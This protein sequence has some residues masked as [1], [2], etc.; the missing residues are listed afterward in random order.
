M[1]CCCAPKAPEND[2]REDDDAT[3][4]HFASSTSAHGFARVVGSRY[5]IFKIFWALLILAGFSIASIN[6]R[7]RFLSF[8][9]HDTTTK[10]SMIF[11]KKLQFPAVTICNANK[12]NQKLLTENDEKFL[13][14]T[15][16]ILFSL[17]YGDDYG[18]DYD[19]AEYGDE[20]YSDDSYPYSDQIYA[21]GARTL[22]QELNALMADINQ[23]YPDGFDMEKFTKEKGWTLNDEN[24]VCS[25]RGFPCNASEDFTHVFTQF[26][27]CYTF[28]GDGALYRYQDQAGAGRGL[29]LGIDIEQ[30]SYSNKLSRGD[31]MDAG[32]FFQV[33]SQFEPPSVEAYGRAVPPGFHAYAGLIRKDSSTME[34]PYGDCNASSTLDYHAVYTMSGCVAECKLGHMMDRCGCKLMHL[35]GPG[36]T[37]SPEIML[38]C[39]R[40]LMGEI[41]RSF[42]KMCEC[43]VPCS[44]VLFE[45]SLSYAAIPSESTKAELALEL[46]TT[47]ENARKN[48]V[49]IDVYFESLNYVESVQMQAVEVTGII[50][51][52]GGQF[53]LFM[54]FSLLTIVEFLEFGVLR[55]ISLLSK[56]PNKKVDVQ[57]INTNKNP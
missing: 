37:C 21:D 35:P 18:D 51:D 30:D 4:G 39:I 8:L 23:W 22:E 2:D 27:N 11:P 57:K 15:A 43:E 55:I 33:H 5:L 54:G 25:F 49:I 16:S 46:G 7:D 38:S 40:P 13:N 10:M 36:A 26:G 29:T 34:P 28:N 3:F 56:K 48:Y 47:V 1:S 52:I 44:S 41:K 24:L 53:G 45:T 12:Y 14:S 19:Y 32:I 50:S 31:R 6:I 9:R 20:D 17:E 42:S